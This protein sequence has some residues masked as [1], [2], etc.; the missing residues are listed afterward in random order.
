MHFYMLFHLLVSKCV[1]CILLKTQLFTGSA[2]T[3]RSVE[4][5]E[6]LGASHGTKNYLPLA[7]CAC[8]PS[9][10]AMLIFSVSFQF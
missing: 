1:S 9:A 8:H 7:S 6:T 5:G 2:E 10:W 3:T 4:A